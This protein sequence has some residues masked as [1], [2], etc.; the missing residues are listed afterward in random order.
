[1]D[2]LLECMRSYLNALDVVEIKR[3]KRLN[4][5]RYDNI[6]FSLDKYYSRQLFSFFLLRLNDY[7]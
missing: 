7:K 2:R 4:D 5:H 6:L 3:L 1:M